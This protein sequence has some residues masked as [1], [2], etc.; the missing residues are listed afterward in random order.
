MNLLELHCMCQLL[1]FRME[2]T[3]DVVPE[4]CEID[5]IF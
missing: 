1:H 2:T 5:C 4:A 3:I